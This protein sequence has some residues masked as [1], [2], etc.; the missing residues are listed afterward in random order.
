MRKFL[1][2][3]LPVSLIL[4]AGCH[5]QKIQ[6][7][8]F[9]Q[10]LSIDGA[11]PDWAQVRPNYSEELEGSLSVCN[12]KEY[13]YLRL[14]TRDL[15]KLSS[16]SRSGLTL[17]F[18]K[19]GKKEKVNGFNYRSTEAERL[20]RGSGDTAKAPP[21]WPRGRSGNFQE[22][23]RPEIILLD[24]S[25]RGDDFH[26][27]DGSKALKASFSADSGVYAFEF[28]IP[29]ALS[30]HHAWAIGTH[31]GETIGI[32]I[33]IGSMEKRP[34]NRG[35]GGLGGGMGPPPGGGP[36]NPGG[37]DGPGGM[38][39]PGR[40]GARPGGGAN[41]FPKDQRLEIWLKVALADALE[42]ST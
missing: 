24:E 5:E 30:P 39:G 7:H 27:Q 40:G 14:Q 42:D 2:L 37:P 1:I 10:G 15:Q 6:S 38:G 8:W 3:S 26:H 12:D 19:N 4:L 20:I 36:G 13:L 22:R 28:A 17:W 11:S 18:D 16:A 25:S 41:G 21:G 35:P 33:Q 9:N 34:S 32:G 23:P 29:M 31:A